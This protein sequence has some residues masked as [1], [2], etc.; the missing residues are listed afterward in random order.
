[1]QV[2][3]HRRY[4]QFFCPR[5]GTTTEVVLLDAYGHFG[6]VGAGVMFEVRRDEFGMLTVTPTPEAEAYLAKI[7]ADWSEDMWE[8][9]R[10]YDEY[11]CPSCDGEI[12][13]DEDCL[14]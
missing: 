6:D 12:R 5:C 4:D 7:R 9:A 13:M 10:Q 8:Y 2:D 11:Q 14:D 3:P 1:M